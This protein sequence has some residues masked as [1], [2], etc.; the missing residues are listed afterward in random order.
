M[1][2]L[3]QYSTSGYA[4]AMCRF[5][6]AC[7]LTHLPNLAQPGVLL[8]FEDF[9]NEHAFGLLARYR[10]RYRCFNDDIQ[11]TG[12]VVTSG[13]INSLKVAGLELKDVRAVFLGAGSAGVVRIFLT[14]PCIRRTRSHEDLDEPRGQFGHGVGH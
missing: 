7:S 1:S 3:L 12:A 14:G 11:G 6:L 5:V 8:Q 4:Q 2:L 13:F 10:D 9:S